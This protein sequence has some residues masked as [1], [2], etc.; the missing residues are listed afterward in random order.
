M[1]LF[2]AFLIG[3]LWGSFFFTL[4]LRF[5]DEATKEAPLKSLCARSNCPICKEPIPAVL[6]IPIVGYLIA[7]GKCQSCGSTISPVYPLTEILYGLLA[8]A[9]VWR[10]GITLYAA[11]MFLILGISIAIAIVD[12]KTLIIPNLLVGAFILLSLY[13]VIVRS[14]FWN[15]FFGLFLCAAFF[16]VIILLFP[17]GFGGGDLK[18]A[19]AM[20]FLLGFELSIVAIETALITGS[21]I[22]ITYAIKTKKG[23]KIKFP[24]APFLTV[25]LIVAFFFGRDILL[26]YYRVIY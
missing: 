22:G 11:I 1:I 3:T 20:G 7:R 24:F 17:G 13:P 16:L 5:S 2:F 19:A 25:G 12:V 9:V 4:A 14:E 18:F 26:I 21:V 6:L 15:T 10:E 23:L 8:I